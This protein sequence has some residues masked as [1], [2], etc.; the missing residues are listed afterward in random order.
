[1]TDRESPLSSEPERAAADR[2]GTG[3]KRPRTA[4]LLQRRYQMYGRLAA[5]L[6]A[7][8]GIG[9]VAYSLGPMLAAGGRVPLGSFVVALLII[10]ALAFVPWLVVRWR[11]RLLKASLDDY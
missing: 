9:L 5:V 8:V 10:V 1:M 3:E 7:V 4:Y 6:G 2:G 11:W